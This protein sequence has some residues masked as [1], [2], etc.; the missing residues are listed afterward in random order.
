MSLDF[1]K[2]NCGKPVRYCMGKNDNGEEIFSCNK[3][4]VCKTYDELY[5]ELELLKRTLKASI[6]AGKDLTIY[7]VGYESYNAAERKINDLCER[8]NVI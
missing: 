5:Q 4:V 2:C 8:Y 1:Q 3:R 7:R 6:R